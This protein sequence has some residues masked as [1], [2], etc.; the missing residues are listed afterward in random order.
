[1]LEPPEVLDY[2]VA[3]P[4]TQEIGQPAGNFIR[5]LR[6][7]TFSRF[8][9]NTWCLSLKIQSKPGQ[10]RDIMLTVLRQRNSSALNS[11]PASMVKSSSDCLLDELCEI[12]IPVQILVTF[13]NTRR[14]YTASLLVNRQTK[15]ATRQFHWGGGLLKSNEESTK[16]KVFQ[17][18]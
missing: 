4:I 18:L 8:K 6:D 10:S 1:M 15:P 3:D 16:V 12:I 5:N 14:P 2:R 13:S 11:C 9:P 7:Y 17:T